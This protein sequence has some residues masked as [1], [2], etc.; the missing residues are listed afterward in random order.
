VT[1]SIHAS[2]VLQHEGPARLERPHA[3]IVL[4][5]LFATSSIAMFDLYLLASSGLH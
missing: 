1:Q 2:G 3:T 5:L 4:A